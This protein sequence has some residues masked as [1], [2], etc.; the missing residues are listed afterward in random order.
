MEREQACRLV[1]SLFESFGPTLA[2]YA[3][4]L[5][6]SRETA[7]DLVQETFMAYYQELRDGKIIENPRAW[8]L[9][10]IRYQ[11]GK[12]SRR[13][14][15]HPEELLPSEI[16]DQMEASEQAEGEPDPEEVRRLF[17]L[18]SAREEE[19]ITL[20]MQSMKYREIAAALGVSGKTV[21][22]LLARALDKMKKGAAAGR[23]GG[24]IA[25]GRGATTDRTL[26]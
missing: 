3:H 11:A 12:I 22:T 1:R 18:L 25:R 13:R 2:R 8:S 19:V 14:G 21:A 4:Q 6:G 10:V 15:T 5:T 23:S 7:D 9:T 16:F 20:R 26:Q 24:A 17:S